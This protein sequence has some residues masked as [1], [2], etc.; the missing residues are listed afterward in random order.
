MTY[1]NYDKDDDTNPVKLDTEEVNIET[2]GDI[3]IEKKAKSSTKSAKKSDK[4]K[5]KKTS[6]KKS[7]THKKKVKKSQVNLAYVPH[8][9]RGGHTVLQLIEMQQHKRIS[10]LGAKENK[11]FENK[12][13]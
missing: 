10:I 2:T 1:G 11:D 4:P 13:L 9:D 3:N 12:Y 7:T 5:S 6:T 8:P